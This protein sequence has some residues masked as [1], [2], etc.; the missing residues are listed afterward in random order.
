M[1][2]ILENLHGRHIFTGKTVCRVGNEHTGFSDCAITD[3]D[4]FYWSSRCHILK[5]NIQRHFKIMENSISPHVKVKISTTN[6]W[7]IQ[8]HH[9]LVK[10]LI[11]CKIIKKFKVKSLLSMTN[12]SKKDK[13][14]HN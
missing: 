11:S 12:Y 8:N 9:F 2:K 3:D 1:E 5:I 13:A 6:D 10:N 7:Q 4:T 14:T